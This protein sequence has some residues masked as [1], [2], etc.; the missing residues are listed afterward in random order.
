M[1]TDNIPEILIPFLQKPSKFKQKAAAFKWEFREW[2]Y[3][4]KLAVI[5]PYM[6][7]QLRHRL[8]HHVYRENADPRV[9]LCCIGKGENRYV[10]E[11]VEWYR[12]IGFSGVVIYDNND[13]DGERFEDVLD[14]HIRSGFVKIV[15]F[16]GRSVVQLAAYEDCYGRF[17]AQ[18]DWIAFFDMDEFLAIG[19]GESIGEYLSSGRFRRS[20]MVHVNWINHTDNG[21]LHYEDRP[22]Q[23]RFPEH[24]PPDARVHR[25]VK[26]IVRGGIP[27]LKWRSS[28]HTPAPNM[29]RCANASG[30]RCRSSSPFCKI[31]NSTVA[32]HHYN[33]K[34][35]GEYLQKV[36]RGYPDQIMHTGSIFSML[37][38]Y[39]RY[40]KPTEEK[41]GMLVDGLTQENG[42]NAVTQDYATAFR[43]Y[44][45]SLCKK[46]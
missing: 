8:T 28:P 39:F 23:E 41:I 19:S 44:F 26:S 18:Y 32:L 40:N 14:D 35:T 30:K 22:V 36:V 17:G 16:R 12:G 46:S 21:R 25:H 15:D 11:F 45:L 31:D 10:R 5:K 3:N 13:L 1:E 33:L 20:E 9:L 38:N 37:S 43:A 34:S 2:K 6:R 24:L 7:A 27:Y 4:A 42:K 29:L